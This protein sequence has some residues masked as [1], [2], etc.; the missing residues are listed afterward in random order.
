[1]RETSALGAELISWGELF[2]AVYLQSE[3][4]KAFQDY[5]F[6]QW[7]FSGIM[8]HI[9]LVLFLMPIHIELK[10]RQ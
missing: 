2:V 10:P 7:H 1:M 4:L 6:R 9:L 8:L 5:G 3:S